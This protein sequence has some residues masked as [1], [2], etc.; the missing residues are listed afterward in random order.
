MYFPWRRSYQPF[1]GHYWHFLAVNHD[2]IEKDIRTVVEET[3][4]FVDWSIKQDT[5]IN[6][7]STI[8]NAVIRITRTEK[9]KREKNTRSIKYIFIIFLLEKSLAR[10]NCLLA[11]LS[12][13]KGQKN[14]DELYILANQSEAPLKSTNRDAGTQ[15]LA[16]LEACELEFLV[17]LSE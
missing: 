10:V 17:W 1:D 6:V 13:R 15:K 4:K 5:M 16:I 8:K 14:I 2:K 12:V 3:A 7:T 11:C 9:V